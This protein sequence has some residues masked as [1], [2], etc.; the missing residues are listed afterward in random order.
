MSQLLWLRTKCQMTYF[1]YASGLSLGMVKPRYWYSIGIYLF[2]R[3]VIRIGSLFKMAVM[4]SVLW[5]R[6]FQFALCVWL[7]LSHSIADYD[8]WHLFPQ[9]KE[10]TQVFFFVCFFIYIIFACVYVFWFTYTCENIYIHMH[11][12]VYMWVYKSDVDIWKTE[13]STSPQNKWRWC[14]L[15]W[16]W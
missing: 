16:W 7:W 6:N 3:L 4:E 11:K 10:R 1:S 13:S 12:Q 9:W 15:W 5:I 2:P 14:W 8:S